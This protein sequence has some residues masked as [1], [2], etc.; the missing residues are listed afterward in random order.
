MDFRLFPFVII[1]VGALFLAVNLDVVPASEVKAL[2]ATWW[3]LLPL[4][5]GLSLLG[6][7]RSREGRPR[8][9]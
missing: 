1:T 4:A 6:H 3:P 7:R 5:V 8:H 9:R 2:L